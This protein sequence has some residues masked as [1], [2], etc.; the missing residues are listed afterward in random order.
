MEYPWQAWMI[1]AMAWAALTPAFYFTFR[2][3][4]KHG[5]WLKWV[6]GALPTII[7]LPFLIAGLR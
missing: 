2:S 1:L 3:V 7:V 4:P 5:H 6:L